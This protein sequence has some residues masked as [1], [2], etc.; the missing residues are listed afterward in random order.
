MGYPKSTCR[1]SRTISKPALFLNPRVSGIFVE[2]LM[3]F[4]YIEYKAMEKYDVVVVGGSCAGAAA[5]VT[6]AKAGRKTLLVD[7]AI[8]P[9]PKLCGGMITDKTFRLL[10][11]VYG[12]DFDRLID[13]R[14]DAFEVHHAALGKVSGYRDPSHVLYM[15][16]RDEFDHAFL[17]EAEKAGCTLLL[18][19]KVIGVPGDGV[20]TDSGRKIGADY[21]IG[22]DGPYSVVR[23]A[24]W[25]DNGRRKTVVVA[26]EVEVPYEALKCFE[27]RGTAIPQI[28]FGFL[29]QG[30]GWVF[31]KMDFS[32]VGI[33]GV[34]PP[35]VRNIREVFLAFLE[36]LCGDI[37]PILSRIKGF[38]V[39]VHNFVKQPGCGK[40]LL[41]G[42]AAGLVD[43]LTGEG[44][45]FGALSG[46]LAART[47][48]GQRSPADTYN[49]LV[50]RHI[51]G[52]FRQARIARSPFFRPSLHALVLRKMGHNGKWCK[53]FLALLSGKMDY[54]QCL[55][56]ILR[57][58]R[59]YPVI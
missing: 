40:I 36:S 45:Y 19:D 42:D 17:K 7:K 37:T 50:R 27:K 12:V 3:V 5:G 25:P 4:L 43:P 18:G 39:P 23:K 58:R 21:I 47:I 20:V 8:F 46:F 1:N 54:K 34:L 15:I 35:G 29:D 9:R 44:I 49:A 57:D 48:L 52:L 41:A 10:K 53:Y 55:M 6:L 14:Y 30:Y 38:P 26:L 32:V 2:R 28:H 13:S 31:P 16:H 59:I 22:A 24:R 51:H 11:E 33:A 56:T